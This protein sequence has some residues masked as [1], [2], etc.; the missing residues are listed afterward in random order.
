M[1]RDY[2]HFVSAN[3]PLRGKDPFGEVRPGAM[4]RIRAPIKPAYVQ[5]VRAKLE[6]NGCFIDDM[7]VILNVPGATICQ[8]TVDMSLDHSQMLAQFAEQSPLLHSKGLW[9]TQY[10]ELQIITM[11]LYTFESPPTYDATPQTVLST[12]LAPMPTAD[13][14]AY[15]RIG[16][17]L[18]YDKN[19]V[20]KDA[21]DD[22]FSNAE[23]QEITLVGV[24][25]T[26]DLRPSPSTSQLHQ[27]RTCVRGEK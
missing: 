15:K 25:W 20:G 12:D 3:I 7:K 23:Q 4:L 13:G 17:F 18:D 5:V 14:S 16:F 2:V 11:R 22:R 10:E 24:Q 9:S 6:S 19:H 26:M 1:R 8:C 27:K 21:I